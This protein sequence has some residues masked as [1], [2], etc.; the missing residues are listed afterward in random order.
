MRSIAS[1]A[2]SSRTIDALK[3]EQ[4]SLLRYEHLDEPSEAL[5]AMAGVADPEQPVPLD[6]LI[7]EFAP[8]TPARPAVPAWMSVLGLV[9]AVGA[10]AALWRYTPLAA[11]TDASQV[12][13]W[14]DAFSAVKWAPL[15]VLFAYTPASL[16]LFPRPIITLFAVIAFGIWG[17]FVLAFA[18]I[19]IAAAA[20]VLPG[21]QAQS[22]R[23]AADRGHAAE[24]PEPGD[25]PARVARD[26]G[27]PARADRALRRGEHRRRHDSRP[28]AP[29]HARQ[30]AG[31]PA[32]HARRDGIRRPARER[33]AQSGA[34]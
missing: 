2:R 8:E 28:A 24:S 4:R 14:A 3:S 29:L 13:E 15:L 17:G 31:H 18:G 7:D 26:D 25:A 12:T 22:R 21:P 6:R 33:P 11:W 5:V 10:L 30:R 23:R 32:G 16:V 19:L 27:D 34:P 20:Y 9:L 1:W